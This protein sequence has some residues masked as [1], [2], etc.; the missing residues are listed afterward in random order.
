MNE[1]RGRAR[2]GVRRKQEDGNRCRGRGVGGWVK[3]KKGI[4]VT[5]VR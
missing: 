1:R 2:N 3:D 4:W 5:N